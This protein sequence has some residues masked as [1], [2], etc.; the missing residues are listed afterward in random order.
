M[1]VVQKKVI[2]HSYVNE[3]MTWLL[4]LTIVN[5]DIIWYSYGY[6]ATYS[7]VK[8]PEGKPGDLKEDG[9][10]CFAAKHEDKMRQ[11][12]LKKMGFWPTR[13]MVWWVWSL[14]DD[15]FPLD[16]TFSKVI[17]DLQWCGIHSTGPPR[18]RTVQ[19]HSE[20]AHSLLQNWPFFN[21]SDQSDRPA[22]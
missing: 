1:T 3:S 22:M 16:I 4:M 13:D 12:Q 14:K 2:F 21:G 15:Q 19:P 17:A 11:D 6:P 9:K 8:L 10:P 18:L 7:Y 20:R 5:Y